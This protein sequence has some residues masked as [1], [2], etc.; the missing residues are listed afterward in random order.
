M[1]KR[2]RT[3]AALRRTAY[4]EA[5]HAVAGRVLGMMCGRATIV[6]DFDAMEAG[7]T[8]TEDPWK[9]DSAWETR[10]KYRA[11]VSVFRGRI[12]SYM[13]GREAEIIAFCRAAGGDRDDRVQI[14]YMAEDQYLKRLRPKVRALL[15]RH[16]HKVEQVA[17]ALLASQTLSAEEIDELVEHSMEPRE[18]EAAAKIDA[19][20]KPLRERWL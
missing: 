15:R 11:S 19:A 9:I 18:R 14:A 13:A 4:H 8:I 7:F 12:M 17:S 3:Q 16:W 20:R 6:P 5:G 1:S 10:G 2:R